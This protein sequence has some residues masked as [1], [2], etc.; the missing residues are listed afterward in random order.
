MIDDSASG[1]IKALTDYS[2]FISLA[3]LILIALTQVILALS[4]IRG[5]SRSRKT[6]LILLSFSF[7][8]NAFTVFTGNAE[9]GTIYAVYVLMAVHVFALLA[10]TSDGA[11]NYTHNRLEKLKE[12]KA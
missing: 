3:I 8:V 4:V 6:L 1:I 12:A 7:V 9:Y 11:V 10:F 2:S 5:R